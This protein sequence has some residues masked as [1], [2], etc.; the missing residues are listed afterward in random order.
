MLRFGL[1]LFFYQIIF[2]S[3]SL[4]ISSQKIILNS[5]IEKELEND[6]DAR[7]KIYKKNNLVIYFDKTNN[8]INDQKK[9]E[10]EYDFADELGKIKTIFKQD[11]KKYYFD[12]RMFESSDKNKLESSFFLE[13]EKFS[14]YLKFKK[15]Y[16][17]F[18]EEIFFTSEVQGKCIKN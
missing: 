10:W 15:Y 6:K 16:Y 8:W 18:N 1:K 14:M 13:L 5:K 4:N 11:K 17:D 3:L 9:K 7:K 2:F 12:Y